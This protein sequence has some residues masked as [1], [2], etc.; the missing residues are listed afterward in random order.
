[1]TRLISAVSSILD[2]FDV[3]ILDQWGVLHNG[4]TPYPSAAA[5][6]NA[7]QSAGKTVFVLSNSGKRADLNR[8]RIAE[9]GLPV[10]GVHRVVT[11]GEALWEDL[12]DGRLLVREVTPRR[13]LVLCGQPQDA[14]RWRDS[15]D[16]LS[17][18]DHLDDRVDA[19]LLMG[20][21]DGI[22]EAHY[23]EI[24][25]AA[26]Q[27][28]LP[29]ICSNPDRRSPRS[30]GT[31]ISPGALAD[32]FAGRGGHVVWYGKP[33]PAIF[34]SVLRDCQNTP[35]DRILMVG[36][37]LEHDVAGAAGLGI[38][39]LFVR[40]GLHAADFIEGAD[41]ATVQAAIDRLV[42]GRHAVTPDLSVPLFA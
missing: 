27:Q 29:L 15:A 36:D 8:T 21:A 3:F 12:R 39:S 32:R 10:D 4:S 24:L 40:G 34:R 9:M 22:G 31:V 1:M 11:S 13:L 35:R 41:E 33:E 38:S 6:M 30:G 26:R 28:G 18:T 17:V 25:D 7:L 42:S 2:E 16:W 19:V 23:D 37:S 14:E 20:V 5:A